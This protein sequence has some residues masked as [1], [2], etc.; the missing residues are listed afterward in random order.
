MI[1]T[2]IILSL[3]FI[4]S[5][6]AFNSKSFCTLHALTAYWVCAFSIDLHLLKFYS[7]VIMLF[8]MKFVVQV[9]CNKALLYVHSWFCAD[10][11]F[12]EHVQKV[13]AADLPEPEVAGSVYW[14]KYMSRNCW[15]ISA[16]WR[17]CS[18]DLR[19]V[20]WRAFRK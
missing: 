2:R 3:S 6:V 11:Y 4:Y 13:P 10:G 19:T 18:I 15:S 1:F 8:F 20:P 16:C 12:T 17:N 5:I 14:R 9:L 7:V